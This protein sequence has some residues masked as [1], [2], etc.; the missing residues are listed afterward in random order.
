MVYKLKS[1]VK[2]EKMFILNKV[3]CVCV[4]TCVCM[5]VC[6]DMCAYVHVYVHLQEHEQRRT[7]DRPCPITFY[8][9]PL[10]KCLSVNLEFL[11]FG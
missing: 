2:L 9:I 5:C 11:K 7:S 3:V 10:S 8:F 1:M 4:Q 6:A